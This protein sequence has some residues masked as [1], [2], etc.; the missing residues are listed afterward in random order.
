MGENVILVIDNSKKKVIIGI[1]E[2][3]E[4]EKGKEWLAEKII[5]GNFPDLWRKAPVCIQEYHTKQT[6]KKKKR[7]PRHCN[8]NSKNQKTTL[9]SKS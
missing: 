5:T 3:G 4:N 6:Q 8:Q 1:P 2:R 9:G 7:I